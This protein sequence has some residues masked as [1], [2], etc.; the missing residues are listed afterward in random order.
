VADRLAAEAD[1]VAELTPGTCAARDAASR[2]RQSVIASIGRVPA[3]YREQL[4][5]AANDLAQRLAACTPPPRPEEE[6]HGEHG[7]KKGHGKK[8]GHDDEQ[9]NDNG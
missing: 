2:F 3:R 5:S 8:H 7:K 1:Q 9:G 4:M 6:G